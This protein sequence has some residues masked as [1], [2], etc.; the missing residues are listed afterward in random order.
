MSLIVHAA[1]SVRRISPANFQVGSYS[2]PKNFQLCSFQPLSFALFSYLDLSLSPRADLYFCLHYYISLPE[3]HTSLWVNHVKIVIFLLLPSSSRFLVWWWDSSPGNVI[4]IQRFDS[5]ENRLLP[6]KYLLAEGTF[7]LWF[8]VGVPAIGVI[9]SIY[10]I[11]IVLGLGFIPLCSWVNMSRHDRVP[12]ILV[13]ATWQ[14]LLDLQLSQSIHS[15]LL[16]MIHLL[17]SVLHWHFYSVTV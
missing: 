3:L 14:Q 13:N 7:C 1:T 17:I 2:H 16:S 15:L 9:I 10:Q 12:L 5:A 6:L 8:R 11:P 4:F